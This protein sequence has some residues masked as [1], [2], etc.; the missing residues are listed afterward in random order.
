MKI[1]FISGHL[2][3]SPD[4]FTEHYV[5]KI[6]A[7]IANGDYFVVGDARGVDVMA[8]LHLMNYKDR[9][10]VYH[11]FSSPRFNKGEFKTSGGFESDSDRDAAMTRVSNYDIAWVRPGRESSGTAKN[12]Q[13][14]AQ[15][16]R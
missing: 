9:V 5:P 15:Y 14:R 13:R 6:N 2:G 10:T 4:E 16:E 11:M 12:I 8:Q 7:A 3:I 1:A